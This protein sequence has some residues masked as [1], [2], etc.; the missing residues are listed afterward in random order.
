[1]LAAPPVVAAVVLEVVLE[2]LTMDV[3][4]VLEGDAVVDRLPGTVV[5]TTVEVEEAELA[6]V[7]TEPEPEP[8]AEAEP[9]A[10]PDEEELEG[11]PPVM[12]KGKEYWK[13]VVLESSWI[14]MP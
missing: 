11:E 4:V 8:D 2:A 6:V 14:L 9:D 1:M 5:T 13:T 3:T 12:W 7:V 10:P